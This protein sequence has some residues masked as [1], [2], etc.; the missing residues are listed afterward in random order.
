MVLAISMSIVEV[1]TARLGTFA[2]HRGL[3]ELSMTPSSRY[4]SLLSGGRARPNHQVA[5]QQ[6]RFAELADIAMLLR[7]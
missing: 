6:V 1:T 7:M 3:L 2:A 4:R 5:H